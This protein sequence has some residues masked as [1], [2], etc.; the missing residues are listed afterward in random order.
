MAITN[1]DRKL[2]MATEILV[3]QPGLSFPTTCSCCGASAIRDVGGRS[4]KSEISL[5]TDKRLPGNRKLVIYLRGI[6]MCW[7]CRSARRKAGLIAFLGHMIGAVGAAWGIF[8]LGAFLE[9]A[10]GGR[11]AQS[12][13]MAIFVPA[14]FLIAEVIGIRLGWVFGK[15][16]ALKVFWPFVRRGARANHAIGIKPYSTSYVDDTRQCWLVAQ[17]D[18]WARQ[19]QGGV[20]VKQ[21]NPP[22][23]VLGKLG[24]ILFGNPFF[25]FFK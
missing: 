9:G 17:D 10:A 25:L 13:A 8:A 12:E 11:A 3:D 16:V 24:L 4:V 15:V 7:P 20:E 21:I 19:V 1:S 14:V 6:P 18:D 22:S 5:V 2:P 23:S